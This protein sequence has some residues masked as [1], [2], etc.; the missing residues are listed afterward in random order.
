MVNYGLIQNGLV[1][2]CIIV[3]E[4]ADNTELFKSLGGTWQ[5][6]PDNVGVGFTYNATTNTYTP[7]KPFPSWVLDTNNQWQAP[8]P[9]PSDGNAYAWM[10]QTKSW[11]KITMTTPVAPLN[12]PQ[13]VAFPPVW[14]DAKANKL[15]VAPDGWPTGTPWP[16]APVTAPTTAPATSN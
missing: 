8:T 4:S 3:N 11:G 6:L 5:Q 1:I 2:N 9:M 13:G 12:W 7:P 14:S 16:M 15:T 10:E